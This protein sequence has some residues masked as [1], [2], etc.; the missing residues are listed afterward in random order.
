[1]KRSKF[2]DGQILAIVKEGEADERS[3]ICVVRT[4]LPSRPT[5]AGRRSTEGWSGA[6]CSG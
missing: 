2:T 5:T 4:A 6:R 1:M 3:P